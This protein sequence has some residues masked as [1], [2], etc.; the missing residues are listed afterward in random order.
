MII[1]L[2]KEIKKNEYR[3]AATPSAVAA[4]VRKGHTVL[5][6]TNCGL[7]SGFPDEDYLA[8]GG[9]LTERDEVY[10]RCDMLYKVKEIEES[11]FDL[12]HEGQIVF[13]YLHSNAHP[14]MTHA[15]LERGVTAVAYED[16]DDEAGG[17]PAL[18]PMSVLA[19]KG[20]FIAAAWF[21]QTVRGGSGRLLSQVPG[22]P[23]PEI[24][25]I[26]C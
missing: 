21:A 10:R 6:E 22:I 7:G 19:G 15:L 26:G 16:I 25:I 13:T 11:E 14:D 4:L 5:F 8:A 24:A 20:G 3:V 17:F 1:G 2:P 12:L 23:T 9:L 18:A